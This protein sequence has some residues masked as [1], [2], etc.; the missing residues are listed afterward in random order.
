MIPCTMPGEP[1]EFE[2][3]CRQ[4]GAEWLKRRRGTVGRPKDFWSPFKS[5]LADGF[6]R[7][8]AYSAMYEPVGTVDHFLSSKNDL[9]L[10]YE[11]DKI[12]ARKAGQPQVEPTCVRH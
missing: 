7:L 3:D 11:W 12:P 2:A 6:G 9:S 8:C 4:K 1:P 5:H 10:A